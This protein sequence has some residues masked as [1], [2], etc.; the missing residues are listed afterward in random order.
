MRE[1]FLGVR[2]EGGAQ[3]NLNKNKEHSGNWLRKLRRN[4]G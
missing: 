1:S 2:V 4:N 3:K